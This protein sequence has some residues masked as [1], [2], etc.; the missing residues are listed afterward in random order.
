MLGSRWAL[1]EA[2]RNVEEWYPVVGVL[3]DMRSTLLL[4]EDRFP[5]FFAGVVKMYD[6]KLQSENS[7]TVPTSRHGLVPNHFLG[8][9]S[10]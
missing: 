9:R 8:P 1:A 2:K 7:I 5:N 4:L 3:E 10:T 6:G